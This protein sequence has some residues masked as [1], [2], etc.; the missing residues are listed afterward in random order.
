MPERPDPPR[1][2]PLTDA[3]WRTVWQHVV[4]ACEASGSALPV[5]SAIRKW[6][7]AAAFESGHFKDC[8]TSSWPTKATVRRWHEETEAFANKVAAFRVDAAEH[9][10][11]EISGGEDDVELWPRSLLGQLDELMDK[12]N[13]RLRSYEEWWHPEARD[14]PYP[15][16]EPERDLWMARLILVWRDDCRLE[17]KN[18]K[19]LRGFLVAAVRPY[20][21]AA[22]GRGTER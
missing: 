16:A 12:L 3:Q 8:M 14:N 9:F 4:A 5:E 11:P 21:G 22:L 18:S 20:L 7:D 13:G 2:A 17:A 10:G 6:V 15:R 19:H 1:F